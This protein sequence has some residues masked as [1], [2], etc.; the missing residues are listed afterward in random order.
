VVESQS[1]RAALALVA[2]LPTDQ[3]EVSVELY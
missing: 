1:T 3:A 2:E